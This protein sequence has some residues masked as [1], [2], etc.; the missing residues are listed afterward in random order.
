MTAFPA[1]SLH[2]GPVMLHYDTVVIGS[3]VGGLFTAALLARAGQRVAV[4]E[5]HYALGGYGHS[6][7]RPGGWRFCAELH[8]VFNCGH[9]EDGGR[10]FRRLGL[11]DEIGFTPL[12]PDGFDRIRFGDAPGYDIVCGLERNAARLADRFPAQAAG[13]RTYFGL[14]AAIGRELY[15]L[16]PG[17]TCFDW[18]CHPLAY[19]HVAGWRRWTVQQLFD[20]L[21]FPPELQAILAGQSMDIAVPPAEASLLIHAGNAYSYDRGPCVPTRGFAHLFGTV[22]A[23]LVR[24]PGCRVQPRAEVTSLKVERGRI[25]AARLRNGDEI[26]GERFVFNGD[27]RLLPGL[28]QTGDGPAPV[29]GWFCRRLGYRYSTS[30]FSIYLGLRDLDLAAHGFGNWN[31]WHYPWA[32]INHCYRGQVAGCAFESPMLFLSTPTLHRT[33]DEGLAPPGGH[34]LVIV[35]MADYAHFARIAAT[36]RDPYR[37]EKQ[38]VA[39][40]LLD[41]VERHC[42]PGLRKHIVRQVTGSP[43][44]NRRYVLAPDG[45]CYGQ[46]LTPQN[47]RFGRLDYRTPWPNLVL[48]GAT[49]GVPSFGGG[50]HVAWQLAARLCGRA[51]EEV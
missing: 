18:L 39:G 37:R 31:V 1:C 22:G 43:L 8:Y 4:L 41:A 33:G 26:R 9:D 17:F 5:R 14:L 51:G 21:G 24:Q 2:S 49:S 40:L 34:Q 38:R 25:V 16:P 10:V 46:A 29:P 12:D 13:L 20:R 30:A 35:T 45:N 15:A 28:V 47:I 3:G 50:L 23:W 32:D 42:V 36:G 7:T 48:V 44:T 19:R 27:P 11:A 6:F